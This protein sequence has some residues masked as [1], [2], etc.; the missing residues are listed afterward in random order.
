MLHHHVNDHFKHEILDDSYE[1]ML[2]IKLTPRSQTGIP[3]V[4]C[5]CYLPPADSP[6]AVDAEKYFDELLC[7]SHKYQNEGVI[8]LCGDFNARCS[9]Q[10]EYISGVDHVPNR[11]V[12]DFER[13]KQGDLLIDFM[14]ATNMC[15]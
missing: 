2:W 15:M 1:G 13:N 3:L 9:D 14:V 7:Q 4:I 5:V 8:L 12:L 6:R 10:E 11:K